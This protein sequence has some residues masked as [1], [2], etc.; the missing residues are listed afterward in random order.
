VYLKVRVNTSQDIK[1]VSSESVGFVLCDA[2]SVGDVF[3]CLCFCVSCDVCLSCAA[4]NSARSMYSSC[5]IDASSPH[6]VHE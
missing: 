5:N 2:M 4:C 6:V 1:I 3:P